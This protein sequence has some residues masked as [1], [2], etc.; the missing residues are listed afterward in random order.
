MRDYVAWGKENQ[1]VPLSQVSLGY[2]EI[3]L[4]D[5]TANIYLATAVYLSAG[6]LGIKNSEKLR[7]QDPGNLTFQ[8]DIAALQKLGVTEPL[9]KSFDGAIGSLIQKALMERLEAL[10]KKNME[11]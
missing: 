4:L 9:P 6:L 5:W 1:S 11:D 8:M 7:W 2:W 3:R 10:F